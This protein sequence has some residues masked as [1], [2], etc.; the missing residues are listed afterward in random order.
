MRQPPEAWHEAH[1]PKIITV[2]WAKSRIVFAIFRL[3]TD[4]AGD[5]TFVKF[6]EPTEPA[7]QAVV[8]GEAS[9]ISEG[10]QGTFPRFRVPQNER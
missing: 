1:L 7:S 10:Y 9:E 2:E 6:I 5:L 3:C 4:L 8:L